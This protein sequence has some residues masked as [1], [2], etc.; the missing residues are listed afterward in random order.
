MKQFSLHE[1]A[2]VDAVVSEGGF[3]AAAEKLH[4][5]HT[6]VFTAIKNLEEHLGL[7]LFDR[8]GYRVTLTGPGQAFY[9]QARTLLKDAGTLRALAEHLAGGGESDL[10]IA[11][12]A[13]CPAAAL[14]P[15][16][17]SF[18]AEC[19]LANTRL[20]LH[21]EAIAGPWER[22]FDEEADLIFHP[23]D[24]RDPRLESLP[25]FGVEMVPVV[26][27]GF[28][29]FP[30]SGEITPAQMRGY[31]QCVI[32][33]SSRRG[34][35]TNFFIVDGAR[36]WTVS[37]Q[38]MKK[39]LIVNGLGWGHLPRY[40]VAQELAVGSLLSIA[41]EHFKVVE[42]MVAAA[43]LRQRPHGPVAEQLWRFLQLR[44]PDIK[45]A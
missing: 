32:R 8:A 44:A 25:L 19:D 7:Q 38:A 28:L 11:V 15:L 14:A 40:A 5:S 21:L 24:R 12:G 6:S 45:Q 33:D 23:I 2:C 27:P 36:G 39:E 31:T 18:S 1:L 13:V 30:V 34:S 9:R 16:L 41:G 3:H 43:R 35:T 22:L 37:D 17:K 4:R 42:L 29:D 10:R 20:H 26:A